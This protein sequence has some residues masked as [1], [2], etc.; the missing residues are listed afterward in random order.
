MPAARCATRGRGHARCAPRQIV[1]RRAPMHGGVVPPTLR[2]LMRLLWLATV[3]PLASA[4][5][6][7]SALPKPDADG[8]VVIDSATAGFNATFCHDTVTA[9]DF[10]P[11]RSPQIVH[12]LASVLFRDKQVVEIG[13]RIGDGLFCFG[14]TAR[15]VLTFELDRTYCGVM[16]KRRARFPATHLTVSCH[17]YIGAADDLRTTDVVTWWNQPPHL[18]N[19]QVLSHLKNLSASG[20]LGR[21]ASA[22]PLFEMRNAHDAS[23]W[24][25]LKQVARRH[26]VVSFN[27]QKHC[28]T[29]ASGAARHLCSRSWGTFVV[30]DIPIAS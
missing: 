21:D 8:K 11:K 6:D 17:N 9:A 18:L 20:L 2:S 22:V 14:Q 1:D 30:A 4:A 12:S 15:N 28:N 3:A 13:S 27:E 25:K 26:A 19:Q 29:H 10:S 23:E 16:H 24:S 7:W 5:L